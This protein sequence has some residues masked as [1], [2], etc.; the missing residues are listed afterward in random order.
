MLNRLFTRFAFSLLTLLWLPFDGT[1]ADA[2]PTRP[3]RMLVGFPPGGPTDLTA[4]LVGQYLGESL[5][6][7]IVIDNRPGAG[8]TLSTTLLSRSASDGYTLSLAAN[9]EI[10]IAPNLYTRLAYD[11]LRDIAPVTRVGT[12]PLLLVVHPS[13]AANSI[14]ELVALAKARPGTLN[15]ASSGTGSTA[16]LCAEL[17]KTMAGID[18][19]HVP[20][21]GAGPA[22]SELMGGQVQMLIT[23][24]SAAMPHVKAGKL[25]ALASTGGKRLAVMPDLPTIGETVHG[26]DVNS[27]YGIFA[28]AGT[29]QSIVARLNSEIS[30]IVHR[31]DVDER[32]NGL[33]IEPEGNSSR[34]FASQIK[35]EIAKWSNVIKIARVPLQ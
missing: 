33:G 26:Y 14:R 3:I 25:R 7:Q 24:A 28:P 20:Y 22:M 18:I 19:V 17:F 8:G 27:W 12:S 31:P 2:Y 30:K 1:A 11:P 5:G 35:E 4:R 34:E 10:A 15:F 29:P 6:Q 9:G 32:L 21:K 13:V 16:H 23:G